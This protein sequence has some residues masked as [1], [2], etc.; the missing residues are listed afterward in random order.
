MNKEEWRERPLAQES[1]KDWGFRSWGKSQSKSV[2][3]LGSLEQY[4][5]VF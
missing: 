2:E 5:S 4:S 3:T 1:E